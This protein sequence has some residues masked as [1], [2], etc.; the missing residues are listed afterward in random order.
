MSEQEEGAH[1]GGKA[2]CE[3]EREA[4]STG[5]EEEDDDERRRRGLLW[6]FLSC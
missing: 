3:R 6:S 5:D 2:E 4:Y 1:S